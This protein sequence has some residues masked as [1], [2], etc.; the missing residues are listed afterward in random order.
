MT[1][2]VVE[3][4]FGSSKCDF[5]ID[6]S[7]RGRLI[8]TAR[9]R[10]ILP[11]NAKNRVAVQ[12]FSIPLDADVDRLQSHVERNTH[13][14]IIEIPR[15]QRSSQRSSRSSYSNAAATASNRNHL[16]RSPDV[17]RMLTSPTGGPQLVRDN[18][19]LGKQSSGGNRKLE[20]R[21]DCH[22]YAANELEVFI[23]GRDLIVHGQTRKSISSDPSKQRV[24]KKFTRKI[25][26]PNTVDLPN[27][28]SYLERGE[29][30]VE[31]PLKP[32]VY[33][34]DE[35]IIIPGPPPPSTRST[36]A[37]ISN[38][39]NRVR[40]PAPA[41]SSSNH[42]HHNQQNERSGRRRDYD[43]R[44]NHRIATP[45]RRARSSGSGVG[46][47]LRYPLYVSPR[48][49]DED[50][51]DEDDS[52]GE[53]NRRHLTTIHE[54]RSVHRDDA[55][56]KTIYRSVYSPAANL[57]TSGATT[58]TTTTTN[59]QQKYPSDDDDGYLRF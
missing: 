29:L 58:T 47:G 3:S 56:P 26:F 57:M 18:T 38:L 19:R 48:E 32:G 20:Y 31:A 9:R 45:T 1:R 25:S 46:T 50:E 51:A 2:I 37:Y 44:S 55:A 30:R 16:I 36:A 11:L 40:S 59:R 27:V 21:I 24:S 39:E 34:H 52:R 54:R 23:Q 35:E 4:P 15:Q 14:F 49:L 53:S 10:D 43:H 12:T 8:V 42:R 17:E 5:T 28:V 33:Y 13:R 22:G 7:Q 41:S 6:K